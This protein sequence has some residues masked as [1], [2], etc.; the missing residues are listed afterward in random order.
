M[1]GVRGTVINIHQHGATVRLE[2]GTLAAVA[3]DELAENRPTYVSSHASRAP[4]A[5]VLERRGGHAIV[6]L[7]RSAPR[8]LDAAFEAQM[9]AFLRSTQEWEPADEPPAAE[10]HFIRKKRR[11][12]SFEAR[13]KVT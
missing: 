2:D 4:L 13:N 1:S 12:A 6:A 11:A 3:A 10:R 5:L 7:E 8:L 9:N